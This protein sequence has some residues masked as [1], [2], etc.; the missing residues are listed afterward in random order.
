[1]VTRALKHLPLRCY[2]RL[3]YRL[4]RWIY[5]EE[6]ARGAEA[7]RRMGWTD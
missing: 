5:R 3:P 6:L 2:R 7:T 4:V 1:M